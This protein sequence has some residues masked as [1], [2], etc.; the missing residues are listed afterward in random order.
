MP[1]E[2]TS[3][4]LYIRNL[5]IAKELLPSVKAELEARGDTPDL[6]ITS[7]PD[8]NDKIWGLKKGLTIIGGRTSQGKSS[9]ALQMAY[10]LADQKKDVVFLSLEMTTES[11]IERL[12]CNIERVDNYEMLRGKLKTE[13]FYQE[14]WGRFEKF[15]DIPLKLSCGLGKTFNQI[16]EVIELLEPKPKV[17]I[18]DYIQ[19]IKKTSN[20][21]LEMDDYITR[22]RELCLYHGIAGILVSQNSRKVF[23][24]DTKQPSLAN[25][26]GTGG[27]EE[28][29]DTVI[30]LFWPHFYNENLDRNI[31][32]IIVAKQRNGRTGEHL[33]NFIPENYLFTELTLEQKEKL[34]KEK[35]AIGKA[36][37]IFSGE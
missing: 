37:E 15:M 22:F 20:E 13:P 14:K 23:D 11:L 10:D 18:V 3:T 36:K 2:Q 12:F 8:F 16:N 32:K 6:A 27:L 21:R 1:I 28:S 29:A 24:E 35:G 4:E 5:K 26:K 30:L 19:A 31:Y 33:V 34:N 25:L 7:L 9:L 17:V